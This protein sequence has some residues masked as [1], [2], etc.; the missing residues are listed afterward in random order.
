V[1]AQFLVGFDEP[2]I[3]ETGGVGKRHARR[4]GAPAFVASQIAIGTVL[5]QMSLPL[6]VTDQGLVEVV[7]ERR[8]EIQLAL[9]Y[10]RQRAVSHHCLGERCAVHHRVGLERIALG[11]ACAVR[12][13]VGQ[14]ATI[15]HGDRH[16]VGARFGHGGAHPCI[17][18][19]SGWKAGK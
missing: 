16:A 7:G 6:A 5:G 3:M 19:S 1:D 11:V 18:R 4:D 12:L 10:Q 9:V 13:H 14:S 15:Y 8:V 2:E 17:D